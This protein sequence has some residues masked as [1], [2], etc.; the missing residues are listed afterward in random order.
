MGSVKRL[1]NQSVVALPMSNDP[2]GK[3]LQFVL[4]MKTSDDL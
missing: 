2:C 4:Y 1:V 3:T